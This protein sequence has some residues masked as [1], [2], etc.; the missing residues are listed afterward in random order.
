MLDKSFIGHVFAPRFADVEKGQLKFFAKA[1]GETKDVYLSEEAARAAGHRALPAP[2]TYL[3]SLD[4]IS[5]DPDGIF[6]LLNIDIGTVLHGEQSFDNF[7]QIYAGDRIK[8][9]ARI[10]DIY[11]K[12]GGA[13]EFVVQETTAENQDGEL[14]GVARSVT[15]VR[16]G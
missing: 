4:F 14:V 5:P 1:T 12:K 6:G 11:E 2:P 3:F 16:N 9:S 10:S 8:L 7:G 13:L 15:V